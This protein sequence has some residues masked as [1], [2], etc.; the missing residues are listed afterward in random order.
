[1]IVDSG[2]D[3]Y[4]QRILVATA[5][6]GTVRMAWA[7]ARYNQIVPTNWSK[8]DMTQMMNTFIPLR[9]T[10]ADA[11]NLAV[12]ECL[13]KNFE[14]LLLIE[15]DTMPPVDAFQRFTA[16]MDDGSIPMV[17]GLYFTKSLPPEPLIYRGRGNH[18][19]RG[20]KLE[21]KVWAD[22]VP[23]GCLLVHSK[24]LRA[25]WEQYDSQGL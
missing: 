24:L 1:M 6:R 23:T 2:T 17:S 5:T 7:N 14:W 3:N 13:T 16:Y 18:Y 22:G 4:S 19:F 11:Q 8:T 10:V 25:V 20:W 21:D 15:D 9:Y 12:K